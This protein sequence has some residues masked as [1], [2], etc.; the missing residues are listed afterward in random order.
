LRMHLDPTRSPTTKTARTSLDTL[1]AATG[2]SRLALCYALPELRTQHRAPEALAIRGR[3][4]PRPPN[5]TRPACRCC[6][7]AKDISRPVMVW[8]R[9]DQNVCRRHRLWIGP[10]ANHPDDQSNLAGL[11]EII[12]AQQRHNTLIRRHGRHRVQESF[13]LAQ[14][15]CAD[16][17]RGGTYARSERARRHQQLH[18][19]RPRMTH[20]ATHRTVQYPE[21]IALTAVFAWAHQRGIPNEYDLIGATRFHYDFYDLVRRHV[22]PDYD[23]DRPF[24]PLGG[25]VNFLI[26]NQHSHDDRTASQRRAWSLGYSLPDETS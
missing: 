21:V 16:W 12:H 26:A 20:L 1:A 14:L 5:K 17:D 10:G 24:D 6:M 9:H 11:P 13:H 15:V 7:A 3:T 23:S 4:L 18:D 25:R 22:I 8:M 19:Q 2:H